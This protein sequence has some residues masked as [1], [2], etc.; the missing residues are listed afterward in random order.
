MTEETESAETADL[1]TVIEAPETDADEKGQVETKTAEVE[2]EGDAEDEKKRESAKERRE[3]DKAYKQRLR[4][5][6]ETERSKAEAAEARKAKILDA[7]KQEASPVEADFADYAEFIAAKAVWSYSQKDRERQAGEAG[8]EAEAARLRAKE[9]QT[10]EAKVLQLAW[11]HQ[12]Q[13]AKTRYQDFEAVALDPS[14]PISDAMVGIIQSSDVAADVAY[15]LGKNK[16]VA[17]EIAKLSP[18]EAARAIGRIEASIGSPKPRTETKAPQPIAP[19]KGGATAM[20]DPS[21][22][23]MAEFVAAR[24]AGKI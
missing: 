17:A 12:V 24:K 8:Q 22:M 15:H 6:A 2:P 21:K 16:A 19:L 13:E 10:T 1:E 11:Q 18:V 4:D 3:R 14:V 9:I 20:K 7:G 5:D 23:T